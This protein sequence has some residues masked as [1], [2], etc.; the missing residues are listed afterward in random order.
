MPF[1][2]DERLVPSLD[3]DSAWDVYVRDRQTNTTQLISVDSAG[4]NQPNGSYYPSINLGGGGGSS[5][6]HLPRL[7]GRRRRLGAGWKCPAPCLR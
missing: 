5:R 6:P 3:N 1:E 7:R 4:Q 2:T